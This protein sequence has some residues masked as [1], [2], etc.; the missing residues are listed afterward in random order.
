LI[1]SC[2][3]VNKKA[4]AVRFRL[5]T[6]IFLIKEHAHSAEEKKENFITISNAREKK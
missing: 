6:S 5:E 1:R 4:I 3:N 2:S